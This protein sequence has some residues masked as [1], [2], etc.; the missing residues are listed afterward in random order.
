MARKASGKQKVSKAA[1]AA[2]KKDKAMQKS[3]KIF[4]K[5]LSAYSNT[6]LDVD[7][8]FIL[9]QLEENTMYIA[10]LAQ[11]M[12]HGALKTLLKWH[13]G[14][15]TDNAEPE[16]GPKW[17]G[18]ART[19][20]Q[21]PLDAKLSMM[22]KVITNFPQ[23][24]VSESHDDAEW[25]DCIFQAELWIADDTLIPKHPDIKLLKTLESLAQDRVEK[26]GFSFSAGRPLKVGD[27]SAFVIWDLEGQ[28]LSFNLDY[29]Q[30]SRKTLPTL[31]EEAVWVLSDP[32][33]PSCV[34]HPADEPNSSFAILCHTLFQEV[35][36]W[37]P[38]GK[39]EPMMPCASP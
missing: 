38:S 25:L 26:L 8:Q 29:K 31:P 7:R 21:L 33:S 4:S 2:I 6:A 19:L 3:E 28:S 17:R 5:A 27:K 23:A 36:D 12:R 11:L 35:S 37:K 32:F 1:K 16:K 34:V 13:E 18:K 30:P 20:M 14:E 15:T 10:P 22:Q 9:S 39:W 24:K